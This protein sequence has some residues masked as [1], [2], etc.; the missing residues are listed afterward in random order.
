MASTITPEGA[1]G[2]EPRNHH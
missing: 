1:Q 2:V